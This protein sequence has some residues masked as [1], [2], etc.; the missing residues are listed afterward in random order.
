MAV[1]HFRLGARASTADMPIGRGGGVPVAL[2]GRVVRARFDRHLGS[3]DGLE[4]S[5]FRR[6]RRSRRESDSCQTT[7][8]LALYRA[9]VCRSPGDGELA[10]PLASPSMRCAQCG[11]EFSPRRRWLRSKAWCSSVCR[12]RMTAEARELMLWVARWGSAVQRPATLVRYEDLMHRFVSASLR[13]PDVERR[14]RTSYPYV[15]LGELPIDD[16][17]RVDLTQRMDRSGPG[18]RTSRRGRLSTHRRRR[19]LRV[20]RGPARRAAGFHA[21]PSPQPP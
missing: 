7:L 13:P 15:D 2:F 9:R 8:W 11:R 20:R 1:T 19:S 5:R 6:A 17:G 14:T 16:H 21:E 18:L 3:A 4:V 12:R 10:R